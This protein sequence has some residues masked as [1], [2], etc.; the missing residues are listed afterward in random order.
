MRTENASGKGHNFKQRLRKKSLRHVRK[1]KDVR[2]KSQGVLVAQLIKN[3]P[4]MEETWVRFL[5]QEDPSEK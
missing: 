4:A 2:L 1:R 3:L 5:G